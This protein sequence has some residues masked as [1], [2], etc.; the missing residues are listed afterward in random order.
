VGSPLV[1]DDVVCGTGNNDSLSAMA[2][3]GRRRD[4]A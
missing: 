4:R 1:V 2:G 3:T